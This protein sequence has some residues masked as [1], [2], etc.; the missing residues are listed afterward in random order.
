MAPRKQKDA[1]ALRFNNNSTSIEAGVDEA[2][3]GSFWG[4][5]VA[6]AVIWPP[7]SQWTDEHKKLAPQI[8]DSKTISKKKRAAIAEA[9]KRLAVATGVGIV[10]AKE[11]DEIGMTR[12]NEE[13]FRRA[14]SALSTHYDRALIDGILGANC[15]SEGVEVETIVD[16][17][18]KYLP[19][20]AAS[21]IAKVA[22]DDV[23]RMWCESC[24]ENKELSEKY[25]LMSCMGYGTLRHRTAIKE[26]GILEGH[27]RL[28]MKNLIPSVKPTCLIQDD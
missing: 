14:L 16:G 2:G 25:D 5:L 7:E 21:I 28:F 4:P 19:I 6:G 27:R 26:H 1:L 24:P 18:A 12:A 13:A 17:D 15:G 8:Q 9:I 20:A 10:E 23:I 3:R 11:I 22:H